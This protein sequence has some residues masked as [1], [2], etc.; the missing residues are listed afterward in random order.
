M[1]ARSLEN[2]MTCKACGSSLLVVNREAALVCPGCGIS[3]DF[4]ELSEANLTYEQEVT[5]DVINYFA[6]KRLNHFTEWINSLQAKE[7]TE[8]PKEVIEAVRAEFKKTRTTTRGEI[9][10]TKVRAFLKKLRLNKY[11]EH[12]HNICNILNGAP[13][14]QLPAS[15]EAKLKHM[16]AEI[17]TPFAKHCPANRKNFLSYSYT[18]YKFCELLG[19]DEYLKYF[20]LLKSPEKLYLQDQIWKKI[21][22]EL[23]WEYIASV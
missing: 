19:E 7:N 2:E 9:N 6:Y 11:Y 23:R 8:I 22:K 16:F 14:P 4:F 18:L 21:C 12:S 5:T 15:L 3:R 13:A 1:Q 10:A 20:P 17:Q